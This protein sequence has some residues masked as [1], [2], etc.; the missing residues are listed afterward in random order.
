[1][2]RDDDTPRLAS[3]GRLCDSPHDRAWGC[4]LGDHACAWRRL[5]AWLETHVT[6]DASDAGILL[7]GSEVIDCRA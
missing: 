3:R 4:L 2:T 5:L 1:L 6:D 7:R